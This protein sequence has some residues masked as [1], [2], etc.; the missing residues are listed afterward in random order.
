MQRGYISRKAILNL[1]DEMKGEEPEQGTWE[2][3]WYSA[4]D[5]MYKEVIELPEARPRIKRGEWKQKDDI[6]EC[7]ECEYS[8]EHGGYLAYFNYCPCCGAKME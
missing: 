3:G 7:S 5:T 1:L 2:D 8:F 6:F 4:I